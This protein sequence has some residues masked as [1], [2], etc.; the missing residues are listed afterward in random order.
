MT[1]GHVC[2][3]YDGLFVSG[4]VGARDIFEEFG[5]K[6]TFCVTKLHEAAPCQIDGLHKLQEAGHEIGF[7]TRSHVKMKDYLA[8]NRLRRWL[9]EEVEDGIEDHRALG[10]P[11]ESFSFPFYDFTHRARVKIAPRF[12][13][14]RTHGPLSVGASFIEERIYDRVD[15]HNSIGCIGYLNFEHDQFAGWDATEAILDKIAETGGTGVFAGNIITQTASKGGIKSTHDQIRRF[16]RAVT[17]RNLGF[18]TMAEL[19]GREDAV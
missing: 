18:K 16:L 3:T 4:W 12:K 7:H 5:A 2:L 15:E 13:A 1:Q 9:R 10:F 17:D 6:A 8:Q 19:A 11:A 14:V